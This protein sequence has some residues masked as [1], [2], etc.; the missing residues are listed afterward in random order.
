MTY[1]LEQHDSDQVIHD[2]FVDDGLALEDI[3]RG[4]PRVRSP[5]KTMLEREAVAA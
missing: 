3:S 4:R 5:L 1:A 2:G